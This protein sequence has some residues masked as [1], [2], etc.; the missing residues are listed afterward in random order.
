MV[1]DQ[2]VKIGGGSTM[3]KRWYVLRSKPRKER[4]L[5]KFARSQGHIIFY[6][7][8]PVN[9]VNPR[10]AKIRPYF[11]G[12]MFLHT[13]IAEV[14]PSTFH[15]MPFSQGLV[16]V[17]G[18]PVPV[19]ENIINALHR[20]VEEIWNAG[21]MAFDGLQKGD[22]VFIREGIFEGYRAIFDVRLP[23]SERV[24]VLLEML[25]KRYVPMEVD[26]GLL[27]RVEGK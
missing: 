9:P 6:P 25:N 22:S 20:R 19:P 15:W 16:R 24:R 5:C 17:G 10:A 4:S 1:R 11:P 8:I 27:E 26:V 13:D 7:T 2:V 14:G 23:G 18:E 12:Y 21:G 3:S